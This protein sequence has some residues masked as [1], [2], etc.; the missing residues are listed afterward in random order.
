M[1]D[2]PHPDGPP[3][4]PAVSYEPTDVDVRGILWFAGGLVAVAVS[5]HLLLWWMFDAFGAREDREKRSRFP[6]SAAER[7]SLPQTEFGSPAS[8]TFPPE[9]RLEGLAPKGEGEPKRPEAAAGP[10]LSVEQAMRLVAE[11]SKPK[12]HE[13]GPVRYDQGIPGTGGGSNSGR[14]LPE[15]KR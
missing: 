14:D 10:R 15:A 8:G 11:E 2:T 6:L 13:P 12:G 1:P 7:V 4:N 5:V 9:P 3:Q